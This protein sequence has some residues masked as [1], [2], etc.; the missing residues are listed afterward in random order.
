MA[1]DG[2][3]SRSGSQS[4]PQHLVFGKMHN[5]GQICCFP[6][7]LDFCWWCDI[8]TFVEEVYK[9]AMQFEELLCAVRQDYPNL[10]FKS[11]KRFT[12]RSPRTVIFEQLLYDNGLKVLLGT[13][14]EQDSTPTM[15]PDIEQNYYCLQ[16][17]HEVGHAILQHRDYKVD[18]DRVKMERAAWEQARQLCERYHIYYDEEFVEAELDTYRDWLHRRSLCKRCGLT[19]YQLKTGQYR[20]PRCDD[21]LGGMGG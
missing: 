21:L 15:N 13:Q 20:C 14:L 5:R 7:V 6:L 18:V 1:N 8:I 12:Y 19:C 3:W 9:K 10:V 11:G 17:L 4:R 2:A 16:L